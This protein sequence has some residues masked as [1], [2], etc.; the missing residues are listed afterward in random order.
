MAAE[1]DALADLLK[2]D[3]DDD[4]AYEEVEVMRCV[5]PYISL[6]L[7][8]FMLVSCSDDGD[9]DAASEDLDA[10][11]RSLQAFT[12]KV[13]NMHAR[14]RSSLTQQAYAGCFKTSYSTTAWPGDTKARSDGRLPEK[15]LC[16]DGPQQ[17]ERSL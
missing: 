9:N 3:L 14:Q 16:Q 17:D 5:E 12:N 15:L 4:F 1:A 7:S 13:R 10:A 8:S 6:S 11:L 2:D